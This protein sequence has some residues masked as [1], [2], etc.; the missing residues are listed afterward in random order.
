LFADAFAPVKERRTSI[1]GISSSP[2]AGVDDVVSGGPA[3]QPT[4]ADVDDVEQRAAF[5]SGRGCTPTAGTINRETFLP[6]G[7]LSS[8]VVRRH[9]GVA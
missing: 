6:T 9:G 1:L 8:S 2:A 3:E 4:G 7:W 5:A